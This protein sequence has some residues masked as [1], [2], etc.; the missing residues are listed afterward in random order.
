MCPERIRHRVAHVTEP[1]DLRSN[2]RT[3]RPRLSGTF[4]CEEMQFAALFL[5]AVLALVIGPVSL[6]PA[7]AT[8]RQSYIVRFKDGVDVRREDASLSPAVAAV[9]A[10]LRDMSSTEPRWSSPTPRWPASGR[11]PGWTTVEPDRP[12][13]WRRRRPIPPGGSTGSTND[14][15]RCRGPTAT[16]TAGADVTAYVVDTGIRADHVDFAGRIR[17]GMTVI[18][19]GRGYRRLLRPRHQRGRHGRRVDVRRGQGGDARPRPGLQ[20]CRKELTVSGL[21][22]ALEWIVGR[23][24]ARDAAVVNMSLGSPASSLF[25]SAADRVVAAG[26][27]VVAAAGNEAGDACPNS[28]AGAPPPSP[29]VPP[30]A[31][32]RSPASRTRAPASTCSHRGSASRSTSQLVQYRHRPERRDL[33][34]LTPRRRCR[35]GAPRPAT[36][37]DAGR[38][39]R[40]PRLRCH[41]RRRQEPSS[42][43]PPTACST[44]RRRARPTTTSPR[45]PRSR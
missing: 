21:I 17:P 37:A 34:R 19:D 8:E 6:C 24:H 41:S 32:T 23:S 30:T 18:N 2:Q 43:S 3:S 20:L 44:P 29:S 5:V 42:P 45:Q 40:R 26:V 12:S 22:A 25:D 16:P 35:G 14:P 13:A 38:G 10:R 9:P 28:P 31:P 15:F 11:I 27:T 33:D 4:A 1:P 7:A 36:V 39:S